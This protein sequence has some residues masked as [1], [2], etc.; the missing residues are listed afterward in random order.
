MQTDELT[1]ILH[2]LDIDAG[3]V[4]AGVFASKISILVRALRA[5]DRSVNER[6]AFEYML[7]KL[8]S[9]AP[10]VTLR[11]KR[12]RLPP[13]LGSSVAHL[14][15]AMTAVYNSD[16]TVIQFEPRL[17]R[18]ITKLSVGAAEQFSH[19]ELMFAE[20][21]IRIDDFMYRQ[22]TAAEL[23]ISGADMGVDKTFRG[24]SIG[25]FDGVL[26]EIDARGTMLRGK[27]EARNTRRYHV[28]IL[29][30]FD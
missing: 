8:E 15:N 16:A 27:Q 6:S 10:A 2:G 4:R 20:D 14:C 5:A 22:A 24:I 25:N 30:L 1:L 9:S 3:V 18:Q 21:V 26:A 19:C 12:R 7:V 17:I 13:P 28:G 11:E 23:Q 29:H